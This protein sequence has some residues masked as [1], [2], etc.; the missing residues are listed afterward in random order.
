MPKFTWN[1][2][3]F[4]L[5]LDV[6]VRF[7]DCDPMGHVNN[8]VY[9]TYLEIARTHYWAHV[10]NIRDFRKVNF[11]LARAEID[12][13]HPATVMDTLRIYIRA[14]EFFH[15]SFDFHYVIENRTKGVVAASA[16]TV[17]VTYDYK[18]GKSVPIPEQ[19][20]RIIREF[21]SEAKKIS[22]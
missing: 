9:L 5:W 7:H 21:E 20:L 10:L 4:H 11:I 8:S 19:Q 6:E 17:Q 2:E 14:G 13:L 1:P 3:D 16:K 18:A 22:S 12:F 15:R